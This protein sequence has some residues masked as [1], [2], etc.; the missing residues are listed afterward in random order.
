MVGICAAQHKVQVPRHMLWATAATQALS[1]CFWCACRPHHT[2]HGVHC[3]PAPKTRSDGTQAPRRRCPPTTGT[4]AHAQPTHKDLA[5][6][7]VLQGQPRVRDEVGQAIG[8]AEQ[9]SLCVVGKARLGALNGRLQGQGGCAVRL[10]LHPSKHMQTASR[11]NS[12]HK[13][14]SSA[15]RHVAPATRNKPAI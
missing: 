8:T 14:C 13:L 9:A 12:C 6:V 1:A 2:P 15:A 5:G 11:H 7:P 10:V 4:R 3:L